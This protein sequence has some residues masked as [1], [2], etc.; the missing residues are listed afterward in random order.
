MYVVAKAAKHVASLK[1]QGC[2]WKRV[3][4]WED[5]HSSFVVV[6]CQQAHKAQVH[7]LLTLRSRPV[8]CAQRN[9][10]QGWNRYLR[11][12]KT[13]LSD[14][15]YAAAWKA[16]IQGPAI[17]DAPCQVREDQI[18]FLDLHKLEPGHFAVLQSMH[19]HHSSDEEDWAAMKTTIYI[20]TGWHMRLWTL[21]GLQALGSHLQVLTCLSCIRQ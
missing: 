18:M 3:G 9:N 7:H 2:V 20:W 4:G 6:A 1:L 19:K 17:A 5:L 21:A 13:V 12:L 16:W 15:Y 8:G 10:K 14:E 11:Y